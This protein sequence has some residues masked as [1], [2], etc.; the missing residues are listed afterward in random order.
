MAQELNFNKTAFK[1]T[2]EK[3]KRLKKPLPNPHS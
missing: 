1:K 3:K 2:K